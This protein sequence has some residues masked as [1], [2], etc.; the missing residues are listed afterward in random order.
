MQQD[1]PEAD[2]QATF[3]QAARM[4]YDLDVT[5]NLTPSD[6]AARSPLDEALA[7]VGDRW[8]LLV[9][10]TLLE[11]PRRFNELIAAVP[12]IAPNILSERLKRLE[13]EGIL[14]SRPYSDRPL[15][16]SYQLTADGHALAGSLRMLADWGARASG[17]AEPLRHAECGTPMEARWF[18][19]T[20]SRPV[21]DDEAARLRFV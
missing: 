3:R 18:C 1:T 7:R 5:Q 16:L 20:C 12:G 4:P 6:P 15:R 9:V 13:R 8:S 10:D 19:P 14:V 2:R 17:H 21:P 11:G